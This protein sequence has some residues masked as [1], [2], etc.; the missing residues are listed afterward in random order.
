[1]SKS[2]MASQKQGNQSAPLINTRNGERSQKE[3][4]DGVNLCSREGILIQNNVP[5]DK[6]SG[7]VLFPETKRDQYAYFANQNQ[8]VSL[9]GTEITLLVDA[10]PGLANVRQNLYAAGILD[11]EVDSRVEE[12]YDIETAIFSI[13]L[14][15]TWSVQDPHLGEVAAPQI[16][17]VI[18]VKPLEGIL[19]TEKPEENTQQTALTSLNGKSDDEFI[20]PSN[21]FLVDF[22][23][24]HDTGNI[25]INVEN[26]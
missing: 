3:Q 1:M 21:K 10:T 19:R 18:E 7:H 22:Q 20:I 16:A 11:L 24:N 13:A 12:G 6:I 8:E 9:P 26:I 23:Y 14:I 4:K 2:T 5:V 17:C 15:F 25:D